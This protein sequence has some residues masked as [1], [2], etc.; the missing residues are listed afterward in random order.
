MRICKVKIRDFRA[1]RDLE[2]NFL[3][4]DD[5]PLDLVLLAGPN[6]C[7]K[8]SVLEACLLAVGHKVALGRP[9]PAGYGVLLEIEHEGRKYIKRSGRIL[10]PDSDNAWAHD[11]FEKTS[12][13]Y[14]S[15][16][17]APKLVGSVGLSTGRG[18][19]KPARTEDNTL[20]RLK[21]R[22]VN[23][24][25]VKGFEGYSQQGRNDPGRLFGRMDAIWEEFYPGANAHFSARP[26][27][28]TDD[29]KD[30]E[31]HFDLFLADR[32]HPDGVSVD[33]LSSGEIEL[34][35]MIGTFALQNPPF[36]IV[37][38]DEPELHLHPAWH[39]SVMRALRKVAPSTQF[40]CATHSVDLLDAAYSHERF[41]LLPDKDP[42]NPTEVAGQV[43]GGARQ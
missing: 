37:F 8:T 39:R 43:N 15:S 14:F 40:I 28:N 33:D 21:Q 9:A 36:D 41:T 18:G 16:W 12:V 24:Q 10:E 34:L 5:K 13:F 7:G 20:W 6:G 29:E 22:L 3:G 27:M 19:R 35:S 1:V 25:G 23:L 26:V 38:I 11:K 42:R 2:L 31:V 32:D 30:E 17:R 4:P